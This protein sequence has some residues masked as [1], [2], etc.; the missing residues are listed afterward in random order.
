MAIS[1]RR[2]QVTRAEKL[3]SHHE[4]RPL[5][6]A[7]LSPVNTTDPEIAEHMNRFLDELK[8]FHSHQIRIHLSPKPDGWN[9]KFSVPESVH[10]K[11]QKARDN[12][13]AHAFCK[14][15]AKP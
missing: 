4:N 8:W 13:E 5:S 11:E 10:L 7:L 15:A 9:L 2:R 6:R 1:C 12:R 3:E 14:L